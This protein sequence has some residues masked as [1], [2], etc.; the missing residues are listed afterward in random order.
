MNNNI[1]A[2]HHFA[3]KA[4]DFDKTVAFYRT[5]NFE[6]VHNWSLPQFNLK[7][8]VMLK[9]TGFNC[10]IEICDRNADFPTQGR[11][12]K[13]EEDYTETALL[14]ICF[15][16]LDA[17]KAYDDAISNGAKPLSG[18]ETLQLIN[19][20]KKVQVTNSLVYSPNGEV[21]EFLES[22]LF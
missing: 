20:T 8:C 1:K 15:T 7:R 6:V 11:K 10:Y 19:N 4:Q 18:K 13:H 5:L 21:I 17:Q 14:H 16:V 2:F 22:V 9:N 12:K 3:I